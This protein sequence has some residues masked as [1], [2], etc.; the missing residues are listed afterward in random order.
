MNYH[1]FGHNRHAGWRQALYTLDLNN[2]QAAVPLGFKFI[3]SAQ[4]WDIDTGRLGR[5]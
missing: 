4:G 1:V 3:I 2:A 5:L